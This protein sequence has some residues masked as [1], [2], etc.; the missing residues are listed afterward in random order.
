MRGQGGDCA[1]VPVRWLRV[2]RTQQRLPDGRVWVWL[3]HTL[4]PGG[5]GGR[6]PVQAQ[7]MTSLPA[8]RIL[9]RPA[10]LSIQPTSLVAPR[11]LL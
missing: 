2:R 10:G 1:A 4:R 8:A 9:N 5:R 11:R 3:R 6:E 7:G